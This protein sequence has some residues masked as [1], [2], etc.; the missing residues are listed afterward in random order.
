MQVGTLGERKHSSALKE[1][2]AELWPFNDEAHWEKH[3]QLSTVWREAPNP[4]CP[5]W[6]QSCLFVSVEDAYVVG[7]W[8]FVFVC[9]LATTPQHRFGLGPAVWPTQ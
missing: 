1:I 7:A 5:L 8:R 9:V 4:L 6:R 2:L 3:R